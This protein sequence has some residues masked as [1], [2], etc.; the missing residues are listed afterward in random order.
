MKRS[1]L[2]GFSILSIIIGFIIVFYAAYMLMYSLAAS[3][4][5]G[6]YGVGRLIVPLVLATIWGV[7]FIILDPIG[8]IRAKRKT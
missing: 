7:I 4:I 8:L 1:T 2:Q 6:T 5:Y 3:T